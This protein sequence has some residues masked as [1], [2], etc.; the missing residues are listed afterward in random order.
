MR[1]LFPFLCSA[2]F[3]PSLLSYRQSLRVP[4]FFPLK[5]IRHYPNY[6]STMNCSDFCTA[7]LWP[8]CF[9]LCHNFP[10][11]LRATVQLSQVPVIYIHNHA[12]D[13][14]PGRVEKCSPLFFSHFPMLL[15]LYMKKV[16]LCNY[17]L[18][19]GSIPSLA[20]WPGY[21]FLLLRTLIHI[22]ALGVL[23]Y[24]AG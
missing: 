22:K 8:R 6:S 23:F 17:I 14:D 20:L 15:S 13:L 1:C 11:N 10:I 19:R 3:L 9:Y 2:R 4:Q 24:P 18:F 5:V 16:S 12:M 7:L 21:P